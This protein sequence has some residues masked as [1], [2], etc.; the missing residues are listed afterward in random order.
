[1]SNQLNILVCSDFSNCSDL[2]I[3]AANTIHGKAK[4]QISVLNVIDHP[5]VDNWDSYESLTYSTGQALKKE[6]FAH[7]T[8]S[9]KEQTKACEIKATSEIQFGDPYSTIMDKINQASIDLVIIGYTGKNPHNPNL[10]SLTAKV[11]AAS[12]IPV[13]VIKTPLEIKKIAALVDPYGSKKEIIEWSEKM[14]TLFSSQMI[15]LS[16]FDDHIGRFLGQ[17]KEKFS[18]DLSTLSQGVKEETIKAI[19]KDVRSFLSQNTNAQVIIRSNTESNIAHPLN[20]VMSEE[21]VDTVVMQKHKKSLLEKV[22]IGS[23]TRRMLD[24]FKG[25]LL[26]LPSSNI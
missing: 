21:N 9:L 6:L 15:V 24:I 25:N 18:L 3:R 17:N 26:V 4:A 13:L 2:A 11:V 16:V 23:E 7:A 1:M 12:P 8:S 14:A 10:G 19:D 5:T 22:F 20:A